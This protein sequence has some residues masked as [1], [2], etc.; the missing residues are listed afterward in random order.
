MHY[1]YLI[2]V[3]KSEIFSTGKDGPTTEHI[4]EMLRKYNARTS[5]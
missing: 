2:Y 5:Y 3:S 4:I 1:T